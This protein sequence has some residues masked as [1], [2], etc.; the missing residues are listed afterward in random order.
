[1]RELKLACNRRLRLVVMM[2]W[3]YQPAA[4]HQREPDQAST[5]DWTGHAPSGKSGAAA[6]S[7]KE[8]Q[9]A[10]TSCN[11]PDLR[12]SQRTCRESHVRPQTI[13]RPRQRCGAHAFYQRWP[14]AP[15]HS[16]ALPSCE[17]ARLETVREV[18]DVAARLV[19]SAVMPAKE[20]GGLIEQS[21]KHVTGK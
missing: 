3:P 11:E 9:R 10:A 4:E 21:A 5:C 15:G 2:H 19:E 14:R 12:C 18:I 20:D 16:N 7:C 6:K 1:M 8:L 13:C 17:D